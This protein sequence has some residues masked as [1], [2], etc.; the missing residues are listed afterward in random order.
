MDRAQRALTR[1]VNTAT[2]LAEAVK[3]DIQHG[4]EITDETVLK[5]NAFIIAVNEFSEIDEIA[6]EGFKYDN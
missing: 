5:L 2:D 6:K 3:H 4:R 1:Y